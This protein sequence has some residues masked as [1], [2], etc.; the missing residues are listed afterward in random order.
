MGEARSQMLWSHTSSVLAMLANIHRDANLVT[1]RV[2]D[3]FRG[4]DLAVLE[5]KRS[6]RKPNDAQVRINLLGVREELLVHSLAIGTNKMRL[7][8][9]DQIEPIE[10]TGTLIDRLDTG[11]DDGIVGVATLQA[12]RVDTEN[13]ASQPRSRY[14]NR[15]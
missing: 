4:T 9:N 7:I 13:H 14:G 8:D 11:D 1:D 5:S 6:G 2:E 10:L 12:C 3:V 15:W